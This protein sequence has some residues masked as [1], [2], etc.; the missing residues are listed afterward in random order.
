MVV[1]TYDLGDV[2]VIGPEKKPF[3][4]AVYSILSP[5]GPAIAGAR[6]GEQRTCSVP[7]ARG[8]VVADRDAVAAKW[9]R[10]ELA[11]VRKLTQ[12]SVS[13]GVEPCRRTRGVALR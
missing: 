7:S 2:I 10:Q 12:Q 5:L 3:G 4:L 11:W 8:V 9:L 1:R 13:A 6:G